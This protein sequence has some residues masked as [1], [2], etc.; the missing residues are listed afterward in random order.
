MGYSTEKNR[1][2]NKLVENIFQWNFSLEGKIVDVQ[3]YY[4]K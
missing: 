3:S 1:Y 4:E 2:L